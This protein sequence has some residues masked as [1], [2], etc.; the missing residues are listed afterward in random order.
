MVQ[1]NQNDND[2]TYVQ[3]ARHLPIVIAVE[4]AAIASAVCDRAALADALA[5]W[6]VSG[7]AP[8][9]VEGCQ[10][11]LWCAVQIRVE[12][13]AETRLK[14]LADALEIVTSGFADLCQQLVREPGGVTVYDGKVTA[15]NRD[16][17][18][19]VVHLLRGIFA[20]MDRDTAEGGA[21]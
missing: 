2:S 18:A 7:V 8:G 6:A 21:R 16:C 3:P 17:G 1:A 20:Q 11:L 5:C 19:G 9:F 14:H 15:Y 4:G 10:R 13:D 12:A